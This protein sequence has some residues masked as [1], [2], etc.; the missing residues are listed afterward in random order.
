MK[1]IIYFL[2]EHCISP[3]LPN[4]SISRVPLRSSA[5]RLRS[6]RDI[7]LYHL[8]AW[9][10]KVVEIA[11]G[12][13]IDSH[14][15]EPVD[16]E[17][18]K[19]IAQLTIYHEGPLH[20]RELLNKHGI[21]LIIVPHFKKTYLDGAV[22][23]LTDGDPVVGLTLR[24]DRLD[25]FWFSLLHEL[26]HLVK[27]FDD[28]KSPYFDN[29]DD[30]S[31][32]IKDFEIEADKM[33]EEALIPANKWNGELSNYFDLKGSI[34]E[35]KHYAKKLHI[36]ESILAGRIQYD[37]KDY[38]RFRRLLGNGIPSKLFAQINTKC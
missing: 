5:Y 30:K 12:D 18:M 29:F 13:K 1:P 10:A 21:H 7:D 28:D 36:H 23:F 33:A 4:S 38:Q 17:F 20:A 22:M 9:Q 32:D 19:L 3:V 31:N 15:T 25:N 6:I 35:L 11:A 34:E 37:N 8:T 24:L 27:H 16:E 26:A 14:Y 2:V